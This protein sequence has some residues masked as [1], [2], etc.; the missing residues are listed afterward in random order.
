MEFI[1]SKKGIR[2]NGKTVCGIADVPPM[3]FITF[4]VEL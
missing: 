2:M 4:E 3:D 1:R